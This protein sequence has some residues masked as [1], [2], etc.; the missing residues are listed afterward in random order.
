MLVKH[1][2]CFLHRAFH[3]IIKTIHSLLLIKLQLNV[4]WNKHLV[5]MLL[6]Q[7]LDSPLYTC[8]L[9]YAFLFVFDSLLISQYA[10]QLTAL[11]V[12]KHTSVCHAVL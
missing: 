1:F 4:R 2:F 9:L 10:W 3:V 8:N 5:M 7:Q 12:L 6:F 11:P